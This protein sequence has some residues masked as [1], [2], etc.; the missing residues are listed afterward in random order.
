MSPSPTAVPDASSLRLEVLGKIASGGMARVDLARDADS[1]RLVALKRLHVHLERDPEFVAMFLDE[2][3]MT[4]AVDHPNIVR[5]LGS[6][7]DA[8]GMFL[9]MELVDG[10]S[11]A[12]LA[13]EAHRRGMGMPAELLAFVALQVARGLSAMH[14]LCDQEGN[15]LG[16]VHRDLTPSNVLIGS[17][18]SVRITDFGVAKAAGRTSKTSTDVIKGKTRYLSPEYA[19]SRQVDARSDLYTLGLSLFVVA[20]G[21]RP[22]EESDSIRVVKAILAEQ[23][24]LITDFEPGFD[25]ALAELVDELQR[26]DP[27][28]RPADARAVAERLEA[29]IAAQG[30]TELALQLSLTRFATKCGEGRRERITELSQTTRVADGSGRTDDE[31]G[32]DQATTRVAYAQLGAPEE[33]QTRLARVRA[34]AAPPPSPDRA[35]A[36]ATTRVVSRP[37]PPT[38]VIAPASVV[39]DDS[40]AEVTAQRA[41]LTDD[42]DA[43]VTAQ[44]ASLTDVR[45]LPSDGATGSSAHPATSIWPTVLV[46]SA[47]AAVAVITIILTTPSDGDNEAHPST[48]EAR[49]TPTA[50][51]PGRE[52]DGSEPT[53]SATSGGTAPSSATGTPPIPDGG[54]PAAT[55]GRPPR[56]T[57][58]KRPPPPPG[59]PKPQSCDPSH[60]DYP[61]CL[62]R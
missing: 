8:E 59:K 23:T 2:A 9:V 41:S 38:P 62:S 57:T 18:G 46:S 15:S 31:L 14:E 11:L 53:S 48:T 22:F 56:P 51:P 54:T 61:E 5:L 19:R 52:N 47:V 60:F 30:T 6:G 1:G 49:P 45:R 37:Q 32:D 39:T 7:R 29:W 24:P 50:D 27:S 10:P 17:D 20:T 40:D 26:K 43:E 33:Q 3:W 58:P 4:A 16:L 36:R 34:P 12:G 21:R 55:Q 28:Q 25:R 42:S 35:S 13:A 44:R